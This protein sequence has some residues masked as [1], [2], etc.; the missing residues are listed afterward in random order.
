MKPDGYTNRLTVERD[1]KWREWIEGIPFIPWD[2]NWEI[3]VIPPV[4]GAMVRFRVRKPGAK[5]SVSVYLDC[6]CR[7]GHYSGPYWEIYPGDYDGD[8]ARVAIDEISELQEHI[9][10]GLEHIRDNLEE[11]T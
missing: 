9:R 4:N 2:W 7:L 6:H 1:E 3:Q 10:M 11:Q 8:A 5:H